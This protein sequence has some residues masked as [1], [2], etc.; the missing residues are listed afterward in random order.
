MSTVLSKTARGFTLIEMM[1][2][3]TIMGILAA[4]AIP[5]YRSYI[6]RV[7]RTE[8][9]AALLLASSQMESCFSRAVPP[10][11]A[12]CTAGFPRNTEGSKY[13]IAQNPAPGAATYTLTAT[14]INGQATDSS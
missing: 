6:V 8:A 14:P 9:K 10:S 4:I 12:G 5:T 2:V 13:T 1:V 11:Y 7:N 3:V